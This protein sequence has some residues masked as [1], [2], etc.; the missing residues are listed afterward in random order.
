MAS[1]FAKKCASPG[2]AQV[3]IISR[4]EAY[5]GSCSAP[6]GEMAG[7]F[8]LLHAKIPLDFS[9]D[10]AIVR[11]LR[12]NKANRVREQITLSTREQIFLRW[13]REANAAQFN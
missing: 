13:Q 11:L 6:A 5:A 9:D 8:T 4:L 1:P 3:Q 10:R 12:G 7:E 2:G